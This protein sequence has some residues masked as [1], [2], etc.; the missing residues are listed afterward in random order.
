MG[1]FSGLIVGLLGPFISHL[2]TGMPPTYAVPLMTMELAIYGL[3]TG[4]TYKKLKMNIYLA[5]VISMIFGR[6]AFALGLVVMGLFIELPYGPMQF[7][8]GGIILTGWPGILLQLI[9]IPPA[10]ASLNYRLNKK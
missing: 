4:L 9:V 3:I 10:V 8:A 2:L 5:L 6:L 7:L 1:P